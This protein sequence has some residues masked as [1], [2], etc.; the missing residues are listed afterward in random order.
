VDSAFR[1]VLAREA[2]KPGPELLRRERARTEKLIAHLIDWE[3][4]RADFA[5][6]TLESARLH[7]FAGG[8]L[9]LRVDRIDRMKDGGL[10][11]IDYK[12]GQAKKF[13]ALAQRLPQPQLPAYAI[14][15]GARCSALATV[16]LGREGV[17]VR[18]IADRADRMNRLPAPKK[19]EPG[20]E[21]LMQRWRQQLQA[22]VDQFLRGEAAV[23]PLPDACDY[24]HLSLLCRIDSNAVE[25]D[26]EDESE[27]D[28]DEEMDLNE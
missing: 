19:G 26:E 14:A 21:E 17:T 11:I 8:A 13:D 5:I 27:N 6:D 20:W 24:C 23:Q 28:L 3:L 1:K 10:L 7:P 2:G 15:V 25:S 16:Y 12:S 22:L 4:K 9:L 18:G